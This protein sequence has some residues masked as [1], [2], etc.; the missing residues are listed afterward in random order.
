VATAPRK[1]TLAPTAHLTNDQ[2]H[3]NQNNEI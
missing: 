3:I 1:S 2:N